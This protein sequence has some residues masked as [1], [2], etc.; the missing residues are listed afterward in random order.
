V[1]SLTTAGYASVRFRIG[2]RNRTAA[3]RASADWACH[4]ADAN[5]AVEI[6]CHRSMNLSTRALHNATMSADRGEEDFEW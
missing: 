3:K 1:Q 2:S 5:G 6:C 4:W